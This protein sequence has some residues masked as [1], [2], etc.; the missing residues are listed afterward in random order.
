MEAISIVFYSYIFISLYMLILFVLIYVN[1]R[2]ELF[3]YPKGKPEGVSIIMPC[4]NESETIGEAIESLLKLD[5]PKKMIEIIVVDD[6]SK[7]NSADVVR[8]YSRKYKNVRLIVNKR[9]SGG[10]AEPT[11]IGVKAAKFDYVAVAD[12]DST[13][14]RDALMKMIGFLQADEKVGGVTCYVRAG[15]RNKFF[16]KLQAVEYA[17]IAFTRKLLDG[18]DAVYVTPGPF[19]LY[20][21]NVLI[22]IGLFDTENLTQDIEIVWRMVKNGYKSRMCLATGVSSVTPS[23][24]RGWWRQRIRWNLGG[25]QTILK[26]KGFFLRKGMLGAF[27]LPFFVVSLFLGL[28]GL[29]LFVYL[30]VR[31]VLFSYLATKFSLSV[32]TDL[33]ALSEVNLSLSVLNFFGIVLFIL[34]ALFAVV[35]LTIMQEEKLRN[36]NPFMILFFLLVYLALYPLVL[37]TSVY[38]HIRGDFKW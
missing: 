2:K 14:D 8:K 29:S 3:Y 36:E 13:P 5:Y 7:D 24:L 6:K 19:A 16:E 37:I 23:K 12:A 33:L 9:N 30:F 25:Q 17:V 4:Y 26:Y 22:E 10:A 38:K 34:G 27:I 31:R 11:N 15:N 35:A 28:F 1:S 20:R 32:G 18:V 21:K